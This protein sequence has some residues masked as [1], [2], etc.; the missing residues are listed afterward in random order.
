VKIRASVLDCLFSALGWTRHEQ[1]YRSNSFYRSF[2]RLGV[3]DR[4]EWSGSCHK[5]DLGVDSA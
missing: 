1:Y 4:A 5:G 2:R 3:L